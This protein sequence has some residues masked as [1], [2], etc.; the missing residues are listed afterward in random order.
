M[1]NLAEPIVTVD[2]ETGDVYV[3]IREGTVTKIR[4][5]ADGM[6]FAHYN[7]NGKLLGIEVLKEEPKASWL[8]V[9]DWPK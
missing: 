4:E 3:L 9:E 5:F 6:V 7:K 1:R 2:R 8:P